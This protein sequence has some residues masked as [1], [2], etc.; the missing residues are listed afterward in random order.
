M[1]NYLIRV[2]YHGYMFT[3]F[4][5]GN[6]ERSIEDEIIRS[7]G[8]QIQFVRSASRTDRNVS[9]VSNVIQ[10]RTEL[11][12]R[13]VVHRINSVNGLIAWGYAQVESEFNARHARSRRYLYVLD[14]H[15]IDSDHLEGMLR[16]F[17][18]TH[19]FSNFCRKDH[20]NTVR[21]IDNIVVRRADD[22]ILVEFIGRS[23][24]W[25]QIRSIMAFSIRENSDPFS[26]ET[27][28]PYLSDSERLILLSVD[29]DG[30]SFTDVF[31]KPVLRNI[32][33]RKGRA[34]SDYALLSILQGYTAQE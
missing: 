21:T 26:L 19:D 15:E 18:G 5:K 24:L 7:I 4:Q 6:G 17:V 23:F 12:P 27:R 9:A 29:Y 20:R 3:G 31:E 16:R 2:G 34:A 11:P 32:M 14:A 28:Y 22:M 13:M 1:K 33:S 10:V 8:S 30:I 25:N